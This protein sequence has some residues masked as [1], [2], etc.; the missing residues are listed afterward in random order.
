M[1]SVLI[2]DDNLLVRLGL[3]Y[4]L[5][6]EHRG[7][8]FGEAKS[9]EEADIRLAKRS[10]DV[11]IIEIAIP[12]QDGFQMIRE[13]HRRHPSARV[14]VMSQHTDPHFAQRA[15]QL[16]AAGYFRK[17]GSRADILKAFQAAL[18][19]ANHFEDSPPSAAVAPPKSAHASL[20]AR[21]RAVMSA[22]VAGKRIGEIAVELNL[23]VKT[24]STYKK[25]M[26]DKLG[27]RSIAELVRYAMDRRL[28]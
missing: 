2:I 1:P 15:R 17:N 3:K 21:E 8:A 12:G 14:L 20:S 7:L 9:S 5:S 16:R 22:F 25:R 10:W 28:L 27:L 4:L 24:V 23:S 18:T 13:I 26:L 6:Q 11:V 19:G